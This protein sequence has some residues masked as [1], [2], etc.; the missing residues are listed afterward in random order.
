VDADDGW[1]RLCGSFW[2]PKIEL[3]LPLAVAG[4][5]EARMRFE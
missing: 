1:Q 3:Q 2:L 4:V 5:N